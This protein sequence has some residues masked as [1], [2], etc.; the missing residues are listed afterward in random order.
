M[1]KEVLELFAQVRCELVR[2][3]QQVE[4]KIWET[5]SALP[6]SL[7]HFRI[8]FEDSDVQLNRRLISYE[9]WSEDYL[10][11]HP[12]WLDTD[13][14][15][16]PDFFPVFN[17]LPPDMLRY[18]L[19][20]LRPETLLKTMRVSKSWR[21]ASK[22]VLGETFLRHIKVFCDPQPSP[23][24][25]AEVYLLTKEWGHVEEQKKANL[26]KL[27]AAE[28][29]NNSD[30]ER[31]FQLMERANEYAKGTR[32]A[33]V[34]FEEMIALNLGV[35]SHVSSLETDFRDFAVNF[36][37]NILQWTKEC[38]QIRTE[39]RSCYH[40]SLAESKAVLLPP[41]EPDTLVVTDVPGYCAC[42]TGSGCFL[43][44]LD[45]EW[46]ISTDYPS[47]QEFLQILKRFVSLKCE[48]VKEIAATEQQI[49]SASLDD[50]ELEICVEGLKDLKGEIITASYVRFAVELSALCCD[51][52]LKCDK[53]VQII[54]KSTMPPLEA[55]L[56]EIQRYRFEKTDASDSLL[57]RIQE[58]AAKVSEGKERL[59]FTRYEIKYPEEEEKPECDSEPVFDLKAEFI[60][61]DL[62]V[63]PL[64]LPHIWI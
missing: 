24:E 3:Q 58:I 56:S 36:N 53:I 6:D 62:V 52:E 25:L 32:G 42:S 28:K 61:F 38:D 63:P 4:L 54:E 47:P 43:D 15:E 35:V 11:G 55:I 34:Q 45:D 33:L 50:V 37:D 23:T 16:N 2:L 17:L 8:R 57:E 29:Q 9:D 59:L 64:P 40:P 41:E 18:I 14:A 1:S 22:R 26:T 30:R 44:T 39:L 60:T 12:S 10:T 19:R 48:V 31:I 21:I 27:R 7:P 49:S 20:C 5:G 13:Q 51:L 46:L